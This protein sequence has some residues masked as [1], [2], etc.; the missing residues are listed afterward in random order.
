LFHASSIRIV[1]HIQVKSDL[2]P[3]D[4]SWAEYLAQRSGR[5]SALT[6]SI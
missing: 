6:V 3:Y 1:R 5:N 4:P 2:N